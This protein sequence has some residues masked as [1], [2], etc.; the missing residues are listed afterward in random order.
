MITT[1]GT[2]ETRTI[3]DAAIA[4]SSNTITRAKIRPVPS[5]VP[6]PQSYWP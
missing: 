1:F 6:R 3:I 2:C 5:Q 4:E